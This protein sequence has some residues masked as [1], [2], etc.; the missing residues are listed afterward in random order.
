VLEAPGPD[1][2]GAA[3]SGR[4]PGASCPRCGG[5]PQ[6]ACSALSGEPRVTGSRYLLCARCHGAWAHTR[7]TCPGCGETAGSRLPLYGEEERFPHVRVE[8]CKTCNRYLLGIDLR[9]DA[10]AVPLVDELAMAP[11]DLFAKEQGMTKLVPNMM[12]I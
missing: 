4:G 1:V 10:A 2:A 9:R 8:S 7:L 6:L 12:G 5:P 11:L 3:C